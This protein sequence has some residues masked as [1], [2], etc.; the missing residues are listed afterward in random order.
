MSQPPL[1]SQDFSSSDP[2]AKALELAAAQGNVGVAADII[3]Q[4]KRRAMQSPGTNFGLPEPV[5][6]GAESIHQDA[7][8]VAKGFSKTEQ[9]FGGAGAGLIRAGQGL[10]GLVG[11]PD[12]ATVSAAEG[13]RDS[14]PYTM[15]GNMA[16]LGLS[17]GLGPARAVGMAGNVAGRVMG[18][19]A[20]AW[21]AS[22]P[23][24]AADTAATAGATNAATTPNNRLV[25]GLMAAG[26]AGIAPSAYG[27]VAG[28]RRMMTGTG[29]QIDVGE[30]LRGDIGRTRAD[31]LIDALRSTDPQSELGAMSSA[32]M[33][34]RDPTLQVMESGSRAKRSDLW[35]P[36]DEQNANARWS[37]LRTQAGTPEELGAMRVARNEATGPMRDGALES[38]SW[39]IAQ[40]MGE[41][42]PSVSRLMGILD[43][44]RTGKTRPNTDVQTIVK[45]VDSQLEQGV[46]PAQLYEVRKMLTDGI[47]AGP[48]SELSQAAR[49]ARPQ[50]MEIIGKIDD[51]LEEASGG[52]WRSYLSAYG[53]A[54]PTIQSREAL[55]NIITSL[56]R[57]MPHGVV[58]PVMGQSPGW[59]S[60]GVLRDRFGQ[61][62]LG[63][64][65]VDRLLPEDRRR[66][67]LLIDGLKRQSDSMQA[68]GVL[69]SH[70]AA[71]LANMGRGDAVTRGVVNLA[72]NKAMPVMGSVVASKMFDAA[73]RRAEDEL[74]RLLQN[75]QAL[76]DALLRAKQAEAL[77]RGV[78]R[79]GAA[80]GGAVEY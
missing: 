45:Y 3:A 52:K 68:K 24:M 67:E 14:T 42:P 44:L 13:V 19:E 23:L 69:G 31:Q 47:K 74:S 21:L 36:F 20:P 25:E 9:V 54:S 40:N 41:Q 15:G 6:L 11:T 63:S 55:Q 58:P 72:A 33:L 73:G 10:K 43:G 28:G 71:L 7:A 37:A 80:S 62:E 50:R 22:R 5:R 18:R 61:K 66:L 57:G 65:T 53:N 29:R 30:R 70:T 59:K 8:D 49:A 76:A 60:V 32:S 56:E 78:S 79:T 4:M 48:T 77:A 38:A 12:Q 1:I 16:G 64:Q 27:V 46:T 39:N 2:L 17:F 34:T 26:T 35:Q 75:P 51:V